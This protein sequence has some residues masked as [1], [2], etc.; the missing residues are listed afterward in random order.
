MPAA[1]G[2]FAVPREREHFHARLGDAVDPLERLP[3]EESAAFDGEESRGLARRENRPDLPRIEHLF[4]AIGLLEHLGGKVR[5]HVLEEAPGRI[6]GEPVGHEHR[7]ALAPRVPLDTVERDMGVV[8][9]KRAHARMRH[10]LVLGRERGIR[11][12]TVQS[13]SI[14]RI[15]VQIEHRALRRGSFP[16][17]PPFP[18]SPTVHGPSFPEMRCVR[19]RRRRPQNR[20]STWSRE[21]PSRS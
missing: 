19:Q 13:E 8:I 21:T 16:Q 20:L 11:G 6:A 5:A 17:C 18:H 14:E 2:V 7:K 3:V 10:R 9:G 12:R 4:D 1:Y 15:A